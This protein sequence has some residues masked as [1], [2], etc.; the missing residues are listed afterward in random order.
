[1]SEYECQSDYE[2]L[3]CGSQGSQARVEGCQPGMEKMTWTSIVRRL[4]AVSLEKKI[5]AYRRGGYLG[6][7]MH[8]HYI[9]R[10]A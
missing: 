8:G 7:P 10:L 5:D 4:A 9:I 2:A 3:E 6:L 1:M